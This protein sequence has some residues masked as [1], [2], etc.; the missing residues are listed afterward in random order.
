MANVNA[1]HGFVPVR[2]LSG[3]GGHFPVKR[4]PLLSTNAAIGIGDPVVQTSAGVIDRGAASPAESTFWGIAAEA[5][6]ANDGASTDPNK[7]TI[8]VWCDPDIVFEAQTD[9]GTGTATSQACVGNTANYVAGA[10]VNGV[11]IAEIDESTGGA[12]TNSLPLKILGLY[13]QVGNAFGEFNKLEVAI[14]S[15][16]LKGLTLGV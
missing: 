8:A 11:S 7:N 13:K 16:A 15:S 2:K 9:D 14:N 3:G 6:A 4:M 10:P 5:H 12:T 1:P